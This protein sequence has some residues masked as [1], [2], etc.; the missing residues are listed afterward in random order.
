MSQNKAMTMMLVS[1]VKLVMH[2]TMKELKLSESVKKRRERERERERR[3][4][5]RVRERE[6]ARTSEFEPETTT[7]GIFYKRATRVVPYFPW[8]RLIFVSL[9]K[10]I[11]DMGWTKFYHFHQKQINQMP[12]TASHNNFVVTYSTCF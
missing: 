5:A 6:Q 4:R 2:Q 12:P 10:N 9:H 7:L 3:E 11:S 8:H 1:G